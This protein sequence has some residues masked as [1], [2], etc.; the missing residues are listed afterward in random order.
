MINSQ[1][2]SHSDLNFSSSCLS[3]FST[4][5]REKAILLYCWDRIVVWW[6]G[7]LSG[8]KFSIFYF[9]RFANYWQGH[10][11][12]MTP[13]TVGPWQSLPPW[14]IDHH[15]GDYVPYSLRTLCGFFNVPQNLYMQGLWNGAYCLLS[16]SE[17][18]RKSNRLQLSSKRQYF[19]LNNLKTL[20]VGPGGTWTSSLPL[21]RQ[22]LIQLNSPG[23]GF[24]ESY[25]Q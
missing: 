9:I 8:W 6:W 25:F 14:E 16:F 1:A 7:G 3:L 17:K 22:A 23:G 24:L 13:I 15:T 10:C 12:S 20:S 19:L 5:E 21:G 11:N 18:T 4:Q 2:K